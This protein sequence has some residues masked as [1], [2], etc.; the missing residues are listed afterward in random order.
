MLCVQFQK[1]ASLCRNTKV[2]DRI[3]SLRLSE[4][5]RGGPIPKTVFAVAGELYIFADASDSRADKSLFIAQACR[6]SQKCPGSRNLVH[7]VSR[8]KLYEGGLCVL[9]MLAKLRLPAVPCH[10]GGS[11]A[12]SVACCLMLV[13]GRPISQR[14]FELSATAQPDA[15]C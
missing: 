3:N 5:A 1:C 10:R 14:I 13:A 9:H 15:T 6:P 11:A 12:N 7:F 2:V 4:G 8:P